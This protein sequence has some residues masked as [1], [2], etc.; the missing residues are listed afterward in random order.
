[1]SPSPSGDYSS[2]LVTTPAPTAFLLPNG[3]AQSLFHGDG[4]DQLAVMRNVIARHHISH[5]FGKSIFPHVGRAE[6]N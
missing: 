3:E 5:A 4:L 6:K 2:I 1:V